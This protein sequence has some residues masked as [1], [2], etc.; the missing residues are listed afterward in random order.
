MDSTRT[1]ILAGT[2]GALMGAAS[3][4][5]VVANDAHSL[6]CIGN[7]RQAASLVTM[8]QTET[9]PRDGR[10]G[11]PAASVNAQMI[12]GSLPARSELPP[13]QNLKTGVPA[14][15]PGTA[16]IGKPVVADEE[17]T[18]QIITARLRDP[19]YIYS[20]TLSDVMQSEDMLKLSDQS[21]ERVVQEIMGMISRG[22]IDAR[23]F[24][25]SRK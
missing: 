7:D 12:E 22:E 18:V 6:A 21:R 8:G 20:A 16:A 15:S 11:I 14:A 9:L 13:A 1:W 24:M 5:Y 17:G 10:M 3:M 25:A 19:S 2:A 23:T 4:Y